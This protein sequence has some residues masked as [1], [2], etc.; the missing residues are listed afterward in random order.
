MI[1]RSLHE[2]FLKHRFS[3]WDICHD[4]SPS[5]QDF[6]ISRSFDGHQ[7]LQHDSSIEQIKRLKAALLIG[8]YVAE[9]STDNQD[10]FSQ[11][12]SL[13]QEDEWTFALSFCP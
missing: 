9:L 2:F 8:R 3:I 11:L 1:V 10:A 7:V 6:E 4:R 13:L 12:A 5:I